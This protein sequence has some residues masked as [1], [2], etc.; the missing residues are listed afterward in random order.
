MP[1][2]KLLIAVVLI[3]AVALTYLL[4]M[5]NGG[6]LKA[7]IFD[8][9]S[10]TGSTITAKSLLKSLGNAEVFSDLTVRGTADI[11][12]LNARK[13]AAF[14]GNVEINGV[15]TAGRGLNAQNLTVAGKTI[16]PYKLVNIDSLPSIIVSEVRKL[17][18]ENLVDLSAY[19]TKVYVDDAI[20]TLK[21]YLDAAD[22]TVKEYTD[23]I[24]AALRTELNARIE[25]ITTPSTFEGNVTINNGDVIAEGNLHGTKA[26]VMPAIQS[27]TSG[28]EKSMTL[29]CPSGSYLVGLAYTQDVKTGVITKITAGTCAKI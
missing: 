15:V 24:V 26:T 10:I 16:D 22:V 5:V 21:T 25:G 13:D 19:A 23:G 1:K 4:T 3:A 18:L 14:E 6:D 7:A 12:T 28:T 9:N 29:D 11:Q 20:V 2:S 8:N 27:V 17:D